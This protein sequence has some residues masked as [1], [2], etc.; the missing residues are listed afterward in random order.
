MQIIKGHENLKEKG[1]YCR[2]KLNIWFIYLDN[3][4]YTPSNL[5]ASEV[6]QVLN[7]ATIEL[8]KVDLSE[9]RT[10]AE[11]LSFFINLFTL[12]I[13]HGVMLIVAG[14]LDSVIQL[15]IEQLSTMLQTQIGRLTF[16]S[17]LAYYVGELG[18][19]SAYDIYQH[20]FVGGVTTDFFGI[21]DGSSGMLD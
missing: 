10:S 19:L 7:V 13:T 6:C 8:A 17:K 12:L 11:K 9:M 14:K 3:G 21:G 20:I 16:H 4:Q 18:V 1:S 15:T 2:K 5:T